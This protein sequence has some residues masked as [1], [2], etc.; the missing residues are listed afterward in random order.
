[1]RVIKASVE[2]I[3]DFRKDEMKDA[4]KLMGFDYLEMNFYRR[5]DLDGDLVFYAELY[6]DAVLITVYENNQ[7]IDSDQ[8]ISSIRF[9]D[10][11]EKILADHDIEQ[12]EIIDVDELVTADNGITIKASTNISN[13]MLDEI[14][15]DFGSSHP[16]Y[17]CSFIDA[18]GE[19]INIYPKLDTHE[20]LCEYVEDKYNIELPYQDEALFI[21][22]F[23]W[24]RLRTDPNMCIIELP[25]V[26]HK[27]Q[28]YALEE[29]L[30]FADARY[31][32]GCKM[33]V[34]ALF[35]EYNDYAFGTEYFPK[36]IIKICKR[37]YSSGNLYASTNIFAKKDH[38]TA[39][40]NK[41]TTQD[42]VKKLARVKSSNVWSYAFQPKDKYVGDM[43]MQFKGKQGGP[44]DIYI[45]YNVP[46]KI[47][48]RLVAAPSK[49]HFFWE[50]IRNNVNI[51]YA[52]LTGDKRT[53]LPNGI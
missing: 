4:L 11:V 8:F 22:E 36:D 20:D 7:E 18:N 1:M 27:D 45:Y 12:G 31:T 6:D 48:Q 30:E 16:G 26:M 34:G 37:Y 47:W 43:L 38:N 9:I 3:E 21:R 33:N 14:V 39:Q 28:W 29:W 23:D 10:F 2:K 35:G 5:V 44:G 25:P 50:N 53:H 51:R 17:G 32:N 40:R 42:F 41:T 24:V 49:G 52:K 19:F 15:S 13:N 46:N